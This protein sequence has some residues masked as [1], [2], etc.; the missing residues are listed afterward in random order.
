VE[1]ISSEDTLCASCAD[2]EKCGRLIL[3]PEGC[4]LYLEEGIGDLEFLNQLYSDKERKPHDNL[5]L[6]RL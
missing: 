5:D 1:T 2:K 4:V 6:Q 3:E